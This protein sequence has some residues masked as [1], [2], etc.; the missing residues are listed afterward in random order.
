VLNQLAIALGVLVADRAR[1]YFAP[2]CDKG[3]KIY[4]IRSH[5]VR[6]EGGEYILATGTGDDI[7]HVI[8]N[9]RRATDST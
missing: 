5:R 3:D 1:L 9:V 8:V 2:V 7:R 4:V 6:A